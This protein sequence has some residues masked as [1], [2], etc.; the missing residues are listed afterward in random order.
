MKKQL[1]SM[2]FLLV[3]GGYAMNASAEKVNSEKAK[4]IALKHYYAS[5]PN[6]RVSNVEV[7]NIVSSDDGNESYYVVNYQGGGFAIVSG[8]D[9]AQPILG[10]TDE[11]T[12]DPNS[13][14][15]GLSF[16]L[17]GYERYVN[18][19]V[20]EG[21]ENPAA[22]R[23]WE[24]I[25][26]GSSSRLTNTTSVAPMTTTKWGQ[27]YNNDRDCGMYGTYNKFAPVTGCETKSCGRAYAGCVA[28]AFS[29]V[30]A[31]WKYES[32]PSLDFDWDN[33]P[34]ELRNNTPEVEVDAVAH[35]IR[36]CGDLVDMSYS[37]N[38]SN[39][40]SS[41]VAT[42]LRGMGYPES[43]YE[44]RSSYNDDAW[45]AKIIDHLQNGVPVLYRG[46]SETA[47]HLMIFDGWSHDRYFHINLGWTGYG[48]GNYYLID[49]PEGFTQYHGAIF[50]V[51]PDNIRKVGSILENPIKVKAGSN[52]EID[53]VDARD[54][55]SYG[56][57]YNGYNNQSSEDIFYRFTLTK[58]SEVELS[59]CGSGMS[60]T[61]I[62]LLDENGNLVLE[63]DQARESCPSTDYSYIKTQ[64]SA[65]TYILVSEGY[66]D[67]YGSIKTQ[68]KS[69]VYVEKPGS[70][71]LNP[72]ELPKPTGQNKWEYDFVDSRDNDS[73]GN[74]YVGSTN[75]P[76]ED[77]FYKFEL[78]KKSEVEVSTCGSP[79]SDTFIHLLDA[80]GNM[81]FE[82]DEAYESC[83]S[84]HYSYLKEMLEP[85][86]YYVVSEGYTNSSG[87]INTQIKTEEYVM[88]PGSELAASIPTFLLAINEPSRSY[89]NTLATYGLG[90]HFK[91]YYNQPSEDIFYN[92]ELQTEA[93]VTINTC[94][95]P[96]YDTYIHLLTEEGVE[97]MQN[98]DGGC[99][100][101]RQSTIQARLAPGKYHVVAEAYYYGAGEIKISIE[102]VNINPQSG[103]DFMDMSTGE[104]ELLVDTDG[105]L[106]IA[107]NPVGNVLNIQSAEEEIEWRIIDLSGKVYKAGNVKSIDVSDMN[108]GVWIIE[109]RSA[110]DNKK[111]RFVK[112]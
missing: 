74:K 98:D 53:Y 61:Y 43:V 85:G 102:A 13:M 93:D 33:M 15:E 5:H 110:V 55:R 91:G 23:E 50:N 51:I 47:G 107:P 70:S 12:F 73:Y 6:S 106:N 83:P 62:H 30:L 46:R 16:L 29:Q 111:L 89:T 104:P 42:A 19:I 75:Q 58:N 101:Y 71:F 36:K 59:T 40:Y 108:S 79:M 21:V 57:D 100:T 90:D 1:L 54:N 96:L 87:V 32:S 2:I 28:L 67:A 78:K 10:Y 26:Q 109:I 25:E 9:N 20:S 88:K 39:A 56:N 66:R 24:N 14:P 81:V 80:N 94:G 63:N 7:Q 97:Y 52:G 48:N 34:D 64:L 38:G 60:D 45:V 68:I 82:N 44:N 69:K 18:G 17:A 77:I 35:L 95:S 4:Q 84:T 72:I 41:K 105:E 8:D 3:F 65:G 31:Y 11:G 22:Q 103:P 92:F 112:K 37:C 99:E 76:S 49:D 86:V 27:S